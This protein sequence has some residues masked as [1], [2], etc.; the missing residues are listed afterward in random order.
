MKNWFDFC[1]ENPEK[2]NPNHSA[3][4]FFIISHCNR[5]GWKS[6]FGLPTTMTMEAIGIKSYNTFIKNFKELSDFGFIFIVEK[7][8]NQ[9]SSNIIALSKY[10]KAL[11]KAL[12]K[13]TVKH[14]TK[15]SES[16]QQSISSIDILINN[17][18]NLPITNDILLEKE[19]KDIKKGKSLNLNPKIK[20]IEERR[21]EFNESL[22][23]FFDQYGFQMME[24]FYNYWAELTMDKKKMRFEIQK[25]W[26]TNLR[27]ATWS[28]NN[29][30]FN[31]N[32]TK[33]PISSETGNRKLTID[34]QIAKRQSDFERRLN[35]S[36]ENIPNGD[37]TERY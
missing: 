2:I 29:I 11:D 9:Y 37:D 24:S 33:Q 18:T 7:S 14:L 10:D 5:L 28:K 15:Q 23:P 31:N 22:K 27:L 12:D 21:K 4:Y 25:T 30:K 26:E 19:T 20:D 36:I 13:A 1:F 35:E 3:L 34:E 17:D 32:A 8:K 16:T 6:K